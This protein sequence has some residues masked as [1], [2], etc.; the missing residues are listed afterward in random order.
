[1]NYRNVCELL[2]ILAEDHVQTAGQKI[3]TWLGFDKKY[4]FG[5]N[6]I[7]SHPLQ[8][9]FSDRES[10]I[11]LHSEIDAISKFIS[12]Y[13]EIWE[14]TLIVCRVSL[15][16]IVPCKP[17]SGCMRAIIAFNIK[18]VYYSTHRGFVRL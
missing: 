18:R 10:K 3:V 9:R 5:Y 6:R 15:G 17:C 2:P 4:V 14:A 11:Y 1:M 8:K 16:D 13:V 7:K 12:K